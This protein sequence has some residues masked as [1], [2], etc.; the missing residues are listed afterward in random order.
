MIRKILRNFRDYFLKDNPGLRKYKSYALK[1]VNP[2]QADG[3]FNKFEG[4]QLEKYFQQI[5]DKLGSI[6]I[7]SDT[8]LEIGCGTGRYLKFIE[9]K[10]RNKPTLYGID[11]TEET[12]LNITRKNVGPNV[13]LLVGDFIKDTTL[14][15]EQF[16]KIYSIS[17]LQ[18]IPFFKLNAFFNK[19]KTLLKKDGTGYLVFAPKKNEHS[20]SIN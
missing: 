18:C 3:F 2:L 9:T 10:F 8:V 20:N 14:K 1:H 6:I 13:T 5:N 12:I 19:I 7:E 15:T 11:V 16:D 17:V 4:E